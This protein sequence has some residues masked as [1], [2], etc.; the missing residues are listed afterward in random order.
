MFSKTFS[1]LLLTALSVSA[2]P[3]L[4]ARQGSGIASYYYP[5]GGFGACGNVLQNGDFIVALGTDTWAGGAHCGQTINVQYQGRSIQVTVQDLCEGCAA[6]G[7]NGLDL[8]QG[9]MAALDP[10]YIND[11][12]I[13]VTWSFA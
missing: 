11:G 3:A 4:Q 6:R 2:S 10:N 13:T 12:I 1:A 9:A 5:D 8:S 7:A